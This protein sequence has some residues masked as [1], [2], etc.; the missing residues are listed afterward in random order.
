MRPLS[1]SA[2]TMWK[3]CRILSSVSGNTVA[4]SPR[5]GELLTL[6]T[7]LLPVSVLSVLKVAAQLWLPSPQSRGGQESTTKHCE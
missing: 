4:L 6:R 2:M 7:S 3:G 5:L 1:G